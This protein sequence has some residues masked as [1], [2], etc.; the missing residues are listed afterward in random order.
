M[1]W[2]F[3]LN[4]CG[5]QRILWDPSDSSHKNKK[6]KVGMRFCKSLKRVV[7]AAVRTHV[8]I[9]RAGVTEENLAK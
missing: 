3:L 4:L 6:I 7:G 9:F 8:V 2:K 5:D 1:R